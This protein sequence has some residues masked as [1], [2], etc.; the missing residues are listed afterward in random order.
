[1]AKVLNGFLSAPKNS[2][3]IIN[4]LDEWWLNTGGHLH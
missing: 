2:E 4:P 3:A 1:M